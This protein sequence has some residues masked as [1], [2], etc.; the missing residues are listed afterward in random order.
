MLTRLK[1]D[2]DGWT[3]CHSFSDQVALRVEK[4]YVGQI[5]HEVL[6]QVDS[7]IWKRTLARFIDQVHDAV[8]STI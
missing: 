5:K 1:W 6:R 3:R 4:Q 8:R 7:Q 2:A